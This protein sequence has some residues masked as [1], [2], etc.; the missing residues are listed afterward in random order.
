MNNHLLLIA[1]PDETGLICRITSTLQNHRFNIV[2]NQEFVEHDTGRF[3]MRTDF[4]GKPENSDTLVNSLRVILP[5]GADVRIAENRPRRIVVMC[6]KEAHCLGDLLIRSHFGNMNAEVVAVI[7]NHDTLQ[8]LAERFEVPFHLVSH[9]DVE[10][11]EHEQQIM[12]VIDGYA[13]DYVVLA[14]YMRILSPEFVGRYRHQIVNI[15]HSFLPA[16]IGANPYRQAW[17]RGVKIIGATA[18]FVTDD[19][20][21]GPIIAQDV[22]SVTHRMSARD[23]AK[24]GRDVETNVLARAVQLVLDERVF[25]TGN[26][27]V[28]FE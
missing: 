7:G 8:P 23:M 17:E 14:K 20:D 11:T 27:T 6:T 24:A 26:K 22:T 15:H 3:F 28:I 19:L 18:H 5:E 4:E 9:K 25:V 12:E 21:E 1:C 2:S 16:F 10:R 13:P